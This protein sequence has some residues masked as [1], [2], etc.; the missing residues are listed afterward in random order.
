[1]NCTNKRIIPKQI[2]DKIA[3]STFLAY[4]FRYINKSDIGVEIFDND[5]LCK[6]N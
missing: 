3:S 2:S 1:M 5:Y 6:I 4:S